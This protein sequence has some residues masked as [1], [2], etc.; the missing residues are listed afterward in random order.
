MR[1]RMTKLHTRRESRI[2]LRGHYSPEVSMAPRFLAATA[3]RRINGVITRLSTWRSVPA[4][5]RD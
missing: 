2:G 3:S 5:L 1:L 4:G